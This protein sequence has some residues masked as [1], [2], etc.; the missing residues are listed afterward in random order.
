MTRLCELGQKWK[1][2][3]TPLLW[4]NYTPTYF[5]LTK[6]KNI[7]RILEVGIGFP[8]T[9]G[10]LADGYVTGASLFMWQEFFPDA[11]I[12]ALDI[13][14][15]IFINEGH[16]KS[17]YCDQS[18]VVSLTDAAKKIGGGFDLIIDDGSHIKEHQVA[19]A[20]MFVPLLKPDGVYVIEDVGF[21]RFILSQLPY[22][23]E[24]REFNLLR[25]GDDRLII[26]RKE[27]Q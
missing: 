25:T 11:E 8:D 14:P 9:M 2:D 16:I 12:I 13:K 17:F 1:T 18:D 24:V 19:T 22:K 5:E 3:K 7:T 6:D 4:H 15:E 26:I 27:D 10:H 23:C 21:A 20:K